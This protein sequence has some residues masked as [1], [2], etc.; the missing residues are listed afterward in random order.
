MARVRLLNKEQA[1]PEIREMFQKMEENG[2]RVLNVYKVMALCPQVGYDFLRLGNSILFK[3]TLPPNLRELA[4]LRVG[5]INQAKYEWTHHVP[6]ALRNGVREEQIDALPDW[7]NSGKFNEQE[8]TVL[9]YTD[10]VTRN[11]RIKDDTF[12]GVRSFMSEEGIV[13][14]TTAIGYYGMVCRILEAL[15]V[16]LET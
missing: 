12:A 5:Q 11:I 15:Q 6:I 14:L 16:E 9:R 4:I 7:E 10:E 2:R 13:E 1:S 3:G 8:R